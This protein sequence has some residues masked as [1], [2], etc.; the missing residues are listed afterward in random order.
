MSKR[1]LFPVDGRKSFYG[2]AY[3]VHCDNGEIRCESYGTIVCVI[4]N[5]MALRTWDGYS[6]TTMRHVNSFLRANGLKFGGKK[7]WDKMPVMEV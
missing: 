3:E 5:G 2:K 7:W 4:R 1:E 6:A